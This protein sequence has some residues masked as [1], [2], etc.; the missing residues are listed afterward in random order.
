MPNPRCADVVAGTL[1]AP[2]RWE[3]LLV[4]AAVIGRDAARWKRRLAG[5]AAELEAQIGEAEREDGHDSGLVAG[6]ATQVR[7]S[8]RISRFAV[9]VIEELAAWPRTATWGEW[10]DAFA[11]LAP[12]VLRSARA[13][14]ARAR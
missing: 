10:L 13:R 5:K 6:A 1:R 14:A 7:S 8:W 2:W 9:P 11:R 12:R 3:K 4:E